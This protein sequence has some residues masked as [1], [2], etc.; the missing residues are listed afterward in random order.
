MKKQTKLK[1][2]VIV[3]FGA[4]L[5]NIQAQQAITATGGNASGSGGSASYT[6]GQVV[7]SANAATNGYSVAHGVQQ[8]FEISVVTGI[9]QMDINLEC[10]VYPNPTTN[11]LILKIDDNMV[12]AMHAS[13][14]QS[15]LY[16]LFDTNG[17]MVTTEKIMTAETKIKTGKLVQGSYLLQIIGNNKTVKTFKIIKQ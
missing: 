7:Y 2:S 16:Q 4:L 5:P 9:E 15:L 14:Q 11:Y 17:K 10:A 1:L 6:V 8:P 12:Q 3:L 13:P